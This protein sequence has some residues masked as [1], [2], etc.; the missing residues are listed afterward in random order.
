MSLNCVFL[1]LFTL[2][3][4]LHFAFPCPFFF[5]TVTH[6]Q[7]ITQDPADHAESSH[8]PRHGWYQVLSHR[9]RAPE[10]WFHPHETFMPSCGDTRGLDLVPANFHGNSELSHWEAS[11][12]TPRNIPEFQVLVP[13]LPPTFRVTMIQAQPTCLQE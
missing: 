12:Q 5:S 6:P 2:F 9:Y 10:A 4:L 3:Y 13:T 8:H 11:F 1:L 7:D